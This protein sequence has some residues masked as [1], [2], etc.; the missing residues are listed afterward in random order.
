[1]T[2]K[3]LVT[4][5]LFVLGPTASV[6]AQFFAVVFD[7]TNYA[8]ALLRYAQLQQQYAQLVLT[9]E[10]IRAE[11]LHLVYQ[12]QQV[13]VNMHLRYRG[14]PT[15][16]QPFIASDTYGRTA[17]WTATANTGTAAATG[18]S[19]ATQPLQVYGA[20]LAQV[21]AEEAARVT[22]RFGG[23]ELRDGIAVHALETLGRLR[24]H[25]TTNEAALRDLEDDTFSDGP[26]MN[27][28]IAV[29]N[30]I[31]ATGVRSARLAQDTNNLLV[32][33]LEHQLVEATERRDAAVQGIN[34]HVAFEAEARP[35][36][37]RTTA[38]TT[39]ALT[40]FRIP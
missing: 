31:N 5:G 34:A 3:R 20:A 15:P 26:D 12:A 18:Y 1:M 4:I 25:A 22:V 27:T 17:G 33:V 8:N 24:S 30:K 6:S 14:L 10:Q 36:L 11:Y 23:V 9:Y 13:P 28:Q 29:L 40:T 38:R 7:P 39:E 19:L 37:Q 35:L 32:S 16:W 21:S 2:W